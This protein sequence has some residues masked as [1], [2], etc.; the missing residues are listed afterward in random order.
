ML[1][2]G[3]RRYGAGGNGLLVKRGVGKP[4]LYLAVFVHEHNA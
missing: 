1:N 3:N 2:G 4:Q